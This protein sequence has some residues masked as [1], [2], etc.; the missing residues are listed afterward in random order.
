[1]AEWQEKL[2]HLMKDKNCHSIL[3]KSQA[4]VFM[5]YA[6]SMPP[7]RSDLG[8]IKIF[9]SE[10]SQAEQEDHP[11]YI[12]LPNE[13]QGRMVIAEHKTAKYYEPI[14][15]DLPEVFVRVL[16]ESLDRH[17]RRFLFVNSK[18]EPFTPQC[19]SKWVIRKTRDIFGDKAPGISLLRHAYC[20]ALDLNKLTGLQQDEVAARMGHSTARQ[21]EYRFVN[22]K[23]I[24]EYCRGL[25]RPR[26]AD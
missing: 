4:L 11:N 1:L 15:E 10:P 21:M 17:P 23:P 13:S 6:C 8:S 12:V 5:S 26:L 25:R 16:K 19:I 22:E 18:G 7:K 24:H 20:T 14:M 3:E 2:D 9:G